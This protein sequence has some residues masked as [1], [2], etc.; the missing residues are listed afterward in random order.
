MYITQDHARDR[1]YAVRPQQLAPPAPATHQLTCNTIMDPWLH[2]LSQAEVKQ[3]V[4]HT[5]SAVSAAMSAPAVLCMLHNWYKD[6]APSHLTAGARPWRGRSPHIFAHKAVVGPFLGIAI[7]R[8]ILAGTRVLYSVT[9][10][11][12]CEATPSHPSAALWPDWI[13]LVVVHKAAAE[14]CLGFV[15]MLVFNDKQN[16]LLSEEILRL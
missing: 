15:P 9:R 12:K 7:P 1:S 11:C 8:L 14:L 13:L 16:H 5:S 6:A 10:S 2:A 3:T 4:T